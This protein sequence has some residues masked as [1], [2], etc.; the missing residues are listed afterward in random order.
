SVKGNRQGSLSRWIKRLFETFLEFQ[1]VQQPVENT[2]STGWGGRCGAR[3]GLP[4]SLSAEVFGG[5]N[6]VKGN[7]QGSLSRWIKRL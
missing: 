6:S 5:K 1:K 3:L 4:L 2:F 7:R